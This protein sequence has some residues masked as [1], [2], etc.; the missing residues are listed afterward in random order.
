MATSL[1]LLNTD[2]SAAELERAAAVLRATGFDP[3][4]VSFPQ[5]PA[6]LGLDDI[7][8]RAALL[9]QVVNAVIATDLEGSIIFWNQ[10]ATTLYQWTAAEALGQKLLDLLVPVEAISAARERIAAIVSEG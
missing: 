8:F 9:D 3:Q 5:L 10:F 4:I 2:V 1:R 6:T 7:T